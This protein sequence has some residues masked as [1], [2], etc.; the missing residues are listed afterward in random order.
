MGRIG[1]P[2]L[3]FVSGFV[4]WFGV[5]VIPSLASLQESGF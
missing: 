5:I 3:L 2:E 1:L 4:F